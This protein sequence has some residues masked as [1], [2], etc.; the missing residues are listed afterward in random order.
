MRLRLPNTDED[1]VF[2]I[3]G[4]ILAMTGSLLATVLY[5][6]IW[7]VILATILHQLGLIP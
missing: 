4:K 7:W 1:K 6:M 5:F 3:L 2:M